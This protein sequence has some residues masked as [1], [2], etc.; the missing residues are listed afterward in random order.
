MVQELGGAQEL[1]TGLHKWDLT[2]G[3]RNLGGA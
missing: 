3:M 2:T 1:G